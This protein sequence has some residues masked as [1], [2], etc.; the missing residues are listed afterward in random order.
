MAN[1]YLNYAQSAVQT[2][3]S[4][5]FTP[6]TP[7]QWVPQDYWKTPTICQELVFYM[8]FV[9]DNAYVSTLENARTRGESWLNTCGYYDDLTCWGR[10][11]MS[12]YNYLTSGGGSGADPKNYL[13][14][15]I[16]CHQNFA[17]IGNNVCGGGIWW[18]RYPPSYPGNFKASN[19]TLGAMEIALG[20]YFATKDQQYLDWAKQAWTW[21]KQS[22]MIDAQGY[23]WGGLNEQCKVD[24]MNRPV[25][26]LQGNPLAPLWLMYQATG[27][28]SCLDIAQT[29]VSITMQKMVWSGTQ[30]L[31]ADAD[32]GWNCQNQQWK[33]QHSGETPFKGIFA[34][35]LGNFAAN[36][37]KV[38]DTS[39]QQAAKQY[40]AFLQAN[41]DAVWSNFPNG[42]FGMDWHTPSPNY[43]PNSDDQINACLEY[44]AL[45]VFLGAAQNT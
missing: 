6:N 22:G 3:T 24:C 32:A 23:V 40:A 1:K 37:V 25:V 8:Q 20:L 31:E 12:A 2:L 38:D 10:F 34:G 44:S 18:Q 17:A 28:T 15:A 11:F 45:A 4:K 42:N 5:W 36:L 16:I 9:N 29:I 27:D 39:R 30:I 7:S 14:D 35:F 19:A 26:A 43:Q 13:N 41:A 33:E 21:L